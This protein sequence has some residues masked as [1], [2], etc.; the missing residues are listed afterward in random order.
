MSRCALC[1]NA[2]GRVSRF[3]IRC[4]LRFATDEAGDAEALRAELDDLQARFNALT[5]ET[6]Q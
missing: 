4:R 1:R 6:A 2:V 5:S 3:S